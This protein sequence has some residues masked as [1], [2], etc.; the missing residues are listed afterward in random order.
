MRAKSACP[1]SYRRRRW[2][3]KKY[4]NERNNATNGNDGHSNAFYD[5]P[6]VVFY[7]AGRKHR[8]R[9]NTR[10]ACVSN[11]IIVDSGHVEN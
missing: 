3:I 8:D 7:G 2:A 6:A 9:D 10:H 5:R 11:E 1:S 4:E